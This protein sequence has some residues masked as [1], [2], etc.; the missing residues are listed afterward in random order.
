MSQSPILTHDVLSKGNFGNITLDM[1][2]DISGKPGIMEH[3]QLNQSCI[4][5]DIN[6]YMALFKEFY[7]VFIWS[8]EEIPGI[9]SSIIVH[10][11]KTYPDAKT[12]R[13]KLRPG[14]PR[15]IVVIRLKL[16]NC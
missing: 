12:V 10:E 11:I 7:N 9:D 3:I 16:K 14:H 5:E 13:Q 4:L 2:I 8:Y 6:A 1:F 15:N